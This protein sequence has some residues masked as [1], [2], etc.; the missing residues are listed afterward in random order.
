[1]SFVDLKRIELLGNILAPQRFL[2]IV[3]VG[4]NPLEPA[5]YSPLVEV[6]LAEA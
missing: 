3:D 4:A 2:R 6:G 5:P 1:M